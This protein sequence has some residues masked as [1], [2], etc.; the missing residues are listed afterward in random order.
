MNNPPE[1]YP[2]YPRQRSK[3]GSQLPPFRMSRRKYFS[4][5]AAVLSIVAAIWVASAIGFIPGPWEK[6][7][8]VFF[9]LVAALTGLYILFFN[10]KE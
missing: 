7:C 3:R 2:P 8:F 1:L 5:S 6:I 10:R 4:I 9:T